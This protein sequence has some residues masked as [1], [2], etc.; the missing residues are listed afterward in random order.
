MNEL[1]VNGCGWQ[2]EQNDNLPPTVQ[3][4]MSDALIELKGMKQEMETV[5]YCSEAI[6]LVIFG[7]IT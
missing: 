2:I 7:S 5:H 4:M 3:S 1:T 6:P